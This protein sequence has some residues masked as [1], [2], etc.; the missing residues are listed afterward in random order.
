MSPNSKPLESNF[1]QTR[2]FYR[3]E[4][5]DESVKLMSEEG[6]CGFPESGRPIFQRQKNNEERERQ[7]IDG[8]FS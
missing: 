8:S 5:Q 6:D 2:E 7:N 1:V 3:I 4:N